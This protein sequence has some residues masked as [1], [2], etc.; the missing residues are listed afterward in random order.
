MGRHQEKPFCREPGEAAF[1]RNW[2]RNPL[3]VG[4]VSPSSRALGRHMAEA[5]P[6]G[7]SNGVVVELGPGTGAVT[8]CLLQRRIE[9][10]DLVCLE[11]AP[12]FCTLLRARFPGI[13][14]LQGDA[15]DPPE[16]LWRLVGERPI[17]A[18]VS[19]L[20]LMTRPEGERSHAV[21]RYLERL[22]PGAPFIQFSYA[23]AP[24]VRPERVGALVAISPWIKRNLPPARVLTYRR[25][26]PRTIAA[27]GLPAFTSLPK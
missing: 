27:P 10:D 2:L 12:E 13:H 17:R 3:K 9:P 24:P 5:V 11:Y 6:D 16:A 4:A 8:A 19:S 25:F 14:V 22:P 23:F 20:P 18:V 26:E 7:P 21:S 15:Y 1:L